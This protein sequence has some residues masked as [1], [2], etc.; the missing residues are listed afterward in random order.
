[1]WIISCQP[2]EKLSIK[3]DFL[4]VK[5]DKAHNKISLQTIP[6]FKTIAIVETIYF[7]GNSVVISKVSDKTYGEGESLEFTGDHGRK[8]SF[9]PCLPFALFQ[10][11]IKNDSTS[12]KVFHSIPLCCFVFAEARVVQILAKFIEV[13]WCRFL[14]ALWDGVPNFKVQL[15][16]I[17]NSRILESKI[18]FFVEN[19]FHFLKTRP[20][21]RG[22]STFIFFHFL[23]NIFLM[24]SS[25]PISNS[26]AEMALPRL[27][28]G[29]NLSCLDKTKVSV[30][31]RCIT[32][33]SSL[34]KSRYFF[35]L[36]RISAELITKIARRF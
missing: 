9:F 36:L 25:I 22:K 33:V 16:N 28:S 1:L 8:I 20:Y 10:G 17:L 35:I 21:Q 26:S 11:K 12:F 32:T 18:F 34:A 5:Y 4:T 15:S 24:F 14:L 7:E 3:N 6:S 31:P 13:C 27:T 23:L 2:N 29:D 19:S 30:L